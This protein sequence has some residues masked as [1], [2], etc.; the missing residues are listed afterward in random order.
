M[1]FGAMRRPRV[2]RASRLRRT[3]LAWRFLRKARQP[4]A[5]RSDL[6]ETELV[7]SESASVIAKSAPARAIRGNRAAP[8][9]R[10][11]QKGSGGRLGGGSDINWDDARQGPF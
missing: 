3:L 4:P 1:R 7:L 10:G 9:N 8:R 2:H 5:S 11:Y 6:R